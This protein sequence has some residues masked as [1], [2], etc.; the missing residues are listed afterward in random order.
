MYP[1]KI[2][3]LLKKASLM[4]DRLADPI[5]KPHDLTLTQYKT[6]KFL[7]T[8]PP[9]TVRQVDIE[10]RF[11]ITNPTVTGVLNG[12]EKKGLVERA[13]DPEDGRSKV[14]CP[15]EKAQAMEALLYQLGD[16]VEAELTRNLDAGEREAL[17]RLLKKM[18]AQESS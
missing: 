17:T 3:I 5:L 8:Q 11:S 7:L 4:C 14:I 15:T 16:R 1:D 2:A 18:L 6:L 9:H 10:R 13:A 12:L